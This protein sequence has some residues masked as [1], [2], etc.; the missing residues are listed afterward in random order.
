MI[1]LKRDPELHREAAKQLSEKGFSER[2][3]AK[4]LGLATL[5]FKPMGNRFARKW[6]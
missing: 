6:Q 2:Q 5:R 3:T 4:N 1:V